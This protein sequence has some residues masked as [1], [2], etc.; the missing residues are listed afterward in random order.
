[1]P[2]V[3]V[4]MPVYNGEKYLKDA[5]DSILNQTFIDFEFIIIND[6]SIDNTRKIIESYDDQRILLINQENKGLPIT[7][8]IGIE[9]ARGEFIARMDADDISEENRLMEQVEFMDQNSEVGIC[10]SNINLINDK[11]EHIGHMMY[12]LEHDDIKAQM[13][14]NCPLAHPTVIFRKSF[15]DESGLRYSEGKSEDYDLWTRS[16]YI[17][18]VANINKYLLGYRFGVGVSNNIYK[19]EYLISS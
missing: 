18:K 2:K 14:F 11:S 4:L 9:I 16:V 15:L 19:S 10:G 3:S 5:I 8:N 7:L 12:P 17:T 1:M 6:G 13:L